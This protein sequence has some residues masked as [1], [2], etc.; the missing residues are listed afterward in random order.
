MVWSNSVMPSAP[1][2]AFTITLQLT[3]NI[4]MS[5]DPGHQSQAADFCVCVVSTSETAFYEADKYKYLEVFYGS[6]KY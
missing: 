4:H 5:Y 3:S 6:M 2:G 1:P